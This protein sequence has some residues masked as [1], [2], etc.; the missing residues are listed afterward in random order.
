[1]SYIFTCGSWIRLLFYNTFNGRWDML[2]FNFMGGTQSFG[3]VRSLLEEISTL[4]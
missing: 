4:L 1:M 2:F 3:I